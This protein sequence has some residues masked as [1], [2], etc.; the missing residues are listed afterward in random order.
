MKSKSSCGDGF[1]Q[2]RI[3]R[4]PAPLRAIPG[5][6]AFD[7]NIPDKPLGNSKIIFG[8]RVDRVVIEGG[9]EGNLSDGEEVVYKRDEAFGNFRPSFPCA[10]ARQPREAAI[11]ASPSLSFL[12][13]QLNITFE[14]V[15]TCVSGPNQPRNK[16]D[17]QKSQADWWSD[18]LSHC[19]NA[20]C[21][22]P[23]Y[24]ERIVQLNYVCAEK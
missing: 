12:D 8:K 18:K 22:A 21:V 17:I 4:G 9:K 5:G 20:E 24:R 11:C 13:Q 7:E 10:K 14:R 23:L 15:L 16:A 19:Q 6:F 2:A 1:Q 3:E